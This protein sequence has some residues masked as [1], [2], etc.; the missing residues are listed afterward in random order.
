MI[1]WAR[2]TLGAI[3]IL[4]RVPAPAADLDRG[5]ATSTPAGKR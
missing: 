3:V 2:R 1:R 4:A 5:P